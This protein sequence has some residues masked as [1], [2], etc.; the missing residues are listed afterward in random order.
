MSGNRVRVGRQWCAWVLSH[1]SPLTPA[2]SPAYRGEGGR[3][4][5]FWHVA[6]HWPPGVPV[7]PGAPVPPVGPPAPPAPPAGRI[8]S[9]W[10]LPRPLLCTGIGTT[11]TSPSFSNCS[12]TCDAGATIT[13]VIWSSFTYLSITSRIWSAVTA[14]IFFGYRSQ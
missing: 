5:S 14:L 3:E 13:T 9:P 7:L 8:I 12:F 1:R 10:R 2:L 11:S 4:F 6:V